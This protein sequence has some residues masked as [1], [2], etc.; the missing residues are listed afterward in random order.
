L[1]SFA[2]HR[3]FAR[4]PGASARTR[5]SVELALSPVG[6]SG[7][8]RYANSTEGRVRPSEA[9]QLALSKIFGFAQLLRLLGPSGLP[10]FALAQLRCH[11]S[12]ARVRTPTAAHGFAEGASARTRPS[13]ELA[14]TLWSPTGTQGH[15][16]RAYRA[17]RTLAKLELGLRGPKATSA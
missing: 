3:Q 14:L 5:P 16:L 9:G 7:L 15:A 10:S 8:K 11:S 4:L 13:V 17:S 2:E 6:P 12:Y 1:L